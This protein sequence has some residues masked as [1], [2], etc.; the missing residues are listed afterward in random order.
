MLVQQIAYSR[1]EEHGTH[2]LRAEL[3]RLFRWL[4]DKGVTAIITGER[5]EQSLIRPT[6]PVILASGYITEELRAEAPAAGIRELIY[7]PD[8][9]DDL[10][11]AVARYANAQ[12]AGG[13]PKPSCSDSVRAIGGAPVS[14]ADKTSHW[15][16]L[17][18]SV[19]SGS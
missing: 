5:G 3:R 1:A 10:C 17:A 14:A 15:T 2:M 7:K 9:V 4:T 6:L 18:A 8:T 13:E 16:N 19:A 12:D 11:K